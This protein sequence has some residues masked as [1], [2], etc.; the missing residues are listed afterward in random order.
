MDCSP[1]GSSVHGDSPGKNTK[2]EYYSSI[3]ASSGSSQPRDQTSVS[4]IAGRF[5][6]I[7]AMREAQN[8][9]VGSLSLLQGIFLTQDSN[10][11]SPHPDY[12]TILI[13][14]YIGTGQSLSNSDTVQVTFSY[15]SLSPYTLSYKIK[16]R[17]YNHG[18]TRAFV[19]IQDYK[20][21]K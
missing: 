15:Y 4:R 21:K 2:A 3:I 1:P 20:D 17:N 18:H 16:Q 13:S 6:T 19:D 8:T 14:Y 12:Y 9:G 7:W 5:F 10:Q 11:G